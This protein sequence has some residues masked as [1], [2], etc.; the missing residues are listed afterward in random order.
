MI[1]IV[2]Y[3]AGNTGSVCNALKI[4]DIPYIFSDDPAQLTRSDKIILPGV[5]SFGDAM[6][7]LQGK[8]LIEF[9]KT[10]IQSGKPFLGICLGLQLLFQNSA[11]SPGCSGLGVLPGTIQKIPG[12]LTHKVPHIGWNT[13]RIVKP[14]GIF[15]GIP[16]N[17]FVYFVHSYYIVPRDVDCIAAYTEYGG[18]LPIAVEQD[19]L[20]ALQFHP[21][22]SGEWGLRI[23]QNFV[24]EH[25]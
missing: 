6:E 21:E 11:E 17:A 22:K 5:G 18:E 1:G 25:S 7:H 2:D 19:N 14:T 15:R 24:Q 8:G 13:L 23:L 20:C 10:S 4:L 3:G 9:L 16:H 12:N